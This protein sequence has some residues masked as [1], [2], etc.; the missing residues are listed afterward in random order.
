VALAR[1]HLRHSLLL[2]L[3]E[4]TAALDARAESEVYRRFSELTEGRTAVIVSHRLATVR[5][6]D[7]I[8]V[9]Q[10]DGIVEEGTHDALVAR[11]GLYSELFEMQA[12]GYR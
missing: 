12:A 5:M 2:I 10:N 4:P 6:A 3:G 1:A 11:T 8:V 7:R 9:L